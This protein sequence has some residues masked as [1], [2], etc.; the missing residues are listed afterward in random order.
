LPSSGAWKS[1]R[2]VLPFL[3]EI[4]M[5]RKGEMPV[6]AGGATAGELVGT[7]REEDATVADGP[8]HSGVWADF[9]LREVGV[10]CAMCGSSGGLPLVAKRWEAVMAAVSWSWSLSALRLRRSSSRAAI[11]I[12]SMATGSITGRSSSEEAV[13]DSK[14]RCA[15]NIGDRKGEL[16]DDE[17]TSPDSRACLLRSRPSRGSAP[18]SASMLPELEVWS[19]RPRSWIL[20][21]TTSLTCFPTCVRPVMSGSPQFEPASAGGQ[22][23]P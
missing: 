3:F 9:L 4:R 17:L 16:L 7:S 10:L 8:L 12:P 19:F 23:Q 14:A 5:H 22:V 6:A 2:L 18:P 21:V 15:C 11:I 1:D 13:S 20:R